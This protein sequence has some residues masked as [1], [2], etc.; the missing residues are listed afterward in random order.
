[1]SEMIGGKKT[2][3][4]L[5]AMKIQKA[6]G[7]AIPVASFVDPKDLKDVVILRPSSS[8]IATDPTKIKRH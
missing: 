2:P 4:L 1:M 5:T 7:G 3:S 6:S 8:Q